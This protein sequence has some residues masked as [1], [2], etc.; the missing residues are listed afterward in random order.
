[1]RIWNEIEPSRLCRKHLLGEHVEL[2]A[3]WRIHQKR[4]NGERHGYT[5]H[6]ETV[7]WDGHLFALYQRHDALVEEM[8]RR[9]YNHRSPLPP[10][11][12]T[13][14][15]AF[16]ASEHSGFPPAWDDQEQA[17]AD[18]TVE[19]QCSCQARVLPASSV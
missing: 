9:G 3:L 2:H 6:P 1:M 17:L 14:V 8:Q 5:N 15:A 10:Y 16:A 11:G 13:F 18:K 12:G 19:K 4:L 7:R